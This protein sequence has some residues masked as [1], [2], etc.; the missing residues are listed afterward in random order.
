VLAVTVY[1]SAAGYDH[2]SGMYSVREQNGQ[3]LNHNGR[4]KYE[5]ENGYTLHF[6]EDWEHWKELSQDN[7]NSC[8]RCTKQVRVRKLMYGSLAGKNCTIC[9]K[10]QQGHLLYCKHD[11]CGFILCGD[12][13]GMR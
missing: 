5:N 6:D 4:F 8:P 9:G 11:G 7:N 3:P 1:A 2:A 12:C 13:A 10:P